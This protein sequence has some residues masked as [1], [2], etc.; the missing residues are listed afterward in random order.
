MVPLFRD[1]VSSRDGGRT[2]RVRYYVVAFCKEAVQVECSVLQYGQAGHGARA[3]F[4]FFAFSC[5]VCRRGSF[6]YG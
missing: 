2:D 5:G 3:P 1:R 4:L 6:V